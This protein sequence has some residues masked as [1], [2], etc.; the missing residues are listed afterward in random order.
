MNDESVF[1]GEWRL[2]SYTIMVDPVDYREVNNLI[3]DVFD[4]DG[5]LIGQE[6]LVNRAGHIIEFCSGQEASKALEVIEAVTK[7]NC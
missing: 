4:I 5:N 7:N 2:L 3:R 6:F 1:F